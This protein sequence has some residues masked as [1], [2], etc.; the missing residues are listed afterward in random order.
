M[1]Q[2]H[3]SLLTPVF[4]DARYLRECVESVCSRRIKTGPT[5]YWTIAARISLRRLPRKTRLVMRVSESSAIAASD[6]TRKPQCRQSRY[7]Q[8]VRGVARATA[9]EVRRRMT[10]NV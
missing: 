5:L 2:P 1:S 10:L 3:V 8:I 6:R 9:K 7:E 4:N